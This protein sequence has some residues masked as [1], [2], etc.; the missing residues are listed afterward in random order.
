MV[1]WEL[2]MHSRMLR[3]LNKFRYPRLLHPDEWVSIVRA[4]GHRCAVV[5]TE[6]RV[7]TWGA[8]EQPS[9]L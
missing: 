4:G 2:I 3:L 1:K 6:G 7:F 8:N 5:T 9:S